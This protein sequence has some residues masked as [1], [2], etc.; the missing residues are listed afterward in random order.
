MASMSQNLPIQKPA[1]EKRINLALMALFAFYVIQIVA[2]LQRESI[3]KYFAVDY[4]A[5]WS[6]GH[7]AN[8]VGYAEVYDLNVVRR[9]CRDR[10]MPKHLN[11][12]PFSTITYHPFFSDFY[13]SFSIICPS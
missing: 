2:N 6:A 4:C 10:Y 13:S 9:M 7:V 12:E 1:S 8:T 3:C 11:P 5:F